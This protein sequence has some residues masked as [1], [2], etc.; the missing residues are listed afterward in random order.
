MTVMVTERKNKHASG[1][2]N[3]K[4]AQ[5]CICSGEKEQGHLFV[6]SCGAKSLTEAI[7]NDR[8]KSLQSEELQGAKRKEGQ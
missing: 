7:L 2:K 5:K 3:K 1:N 8:G 6:P 4:A